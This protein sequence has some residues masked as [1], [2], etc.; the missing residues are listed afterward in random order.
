MAQLYGLKQEEL[1]AEHLYRLMKENKVAYEDISDINTQKMMRGKQ[2]RF[3]K[4]EPLERKRAGL[5]RATQPTKK[6]KRRAMDY[7]DSD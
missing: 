2:R 7:E 4:E 3:T 6:K 1:T 5:R